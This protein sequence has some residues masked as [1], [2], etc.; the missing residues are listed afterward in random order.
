MHV[1]TVAYSRIYVN[2]SLPEMYVY[3]QSTYKFTIHQPPATS[4]FSS[5]SFPVAVP[6]LWNKRCANTIDMHASSLGTHKS[7]LKTELFTQA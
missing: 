1:A 5:R 6:T 7:R 2:T 4:A 3:Q